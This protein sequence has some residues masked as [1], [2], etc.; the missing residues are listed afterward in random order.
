VNY[1]FG[2]SSRQRALF[3]R[4]IFYGSGNNPFSQARHL[5]KSIYAKTA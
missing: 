4:D 5:K 3:K 1:Y 2:G